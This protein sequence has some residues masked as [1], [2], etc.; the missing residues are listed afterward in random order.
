M[1]PM[2]TWWGRLVVGLEG[3]WWVVGLL[4]SDGDEVEAGWGLRLLEEGEGT[5]TGSGII[6][7]LMANSFS[8]FMEVEAG[9][10]LV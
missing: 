4:D 7:D 8:L 9:E 2:S 5:R 6:E 10:A 1:L 3:A